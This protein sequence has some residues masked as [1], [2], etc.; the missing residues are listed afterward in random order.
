MTIRAGAV[1]DALRLT[2]VLPAV[3]PALGT[4]LF[5]GRAGCPHRADSDHIRLASLALVTGVTSGLIKKPMTICPQWDI[6][7]T[8]LWTFGLNALN[9][10]SHGATTRILDTWC[11]SGR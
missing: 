3:F 10:T 8:A 7:G 4:D 1:A 2:N 6:L 5:E 9:S 11:A